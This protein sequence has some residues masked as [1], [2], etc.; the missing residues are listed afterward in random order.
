MTLHDFLY[1]LTKKYYFISAPNQAI[2]IPWA[3]QEVLQVFQS[4]QLLSEFMRFQIPQPKSRL[5]PRNM[6]NGF[7]SDHLNIEKKIESY[8]SHIPREWK[9]NA[10]GDYKLFLRKIY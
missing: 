5:I 1:D 7:Q 9:G 10:E 8:I 2:Q 3:F 4:K 6:D